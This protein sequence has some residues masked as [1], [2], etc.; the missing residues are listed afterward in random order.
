[1]ADNESETDE[2]G[3]KILRSIPWQNFKV[4]DL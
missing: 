1:M 3:E 4:T 2:N